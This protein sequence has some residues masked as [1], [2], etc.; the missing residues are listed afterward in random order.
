MDRHYVR[1]FSLGLDFCKVLAAYTDIP[2]DIHFMI[3]NPDDFITDFAQFKNCLL[4][5]HPEVCLHP[6]RT[7]QSIK[8]YGARAGISLGPDRICIMTVHPGYAPEREV[9]GNVSWQNLPQMRD[10]QVFVTGT[11]SIFEQEGDLSKNI[12]RFRSILEEAEKS[13]ADS[14][15]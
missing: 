2:L 5:F 11:S 9:D 1:N 6:M 3:E 8:S 4:T 7:I 15:S 12:L 14:N 13:P 10:A